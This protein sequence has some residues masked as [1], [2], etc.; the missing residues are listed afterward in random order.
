MPLAE[1]ARWALHGYPVR[2]KTGELKFLSSLTALSLE[3]AMIPVCNRPVL[4]RANPGD[5]REIMV[6]PARLEDL[7]V[8]ATEETYRQVLKMRTLDALE[9]QPQ[10]CCQHGTPYGYAC[11]ECLDGDVQ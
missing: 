7:T 4:G 3:G 6:A 9:P 1:M 8:D 5:M 2:L 11:P 10:T